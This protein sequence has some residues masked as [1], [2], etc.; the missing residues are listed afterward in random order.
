MLPFLDLVLTWNTGISYGL[1]QQDSAFGRWAL[2]GL[3]IVAS[4]LLWVW[5]ARADIAANALWRSA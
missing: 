1:F 5:L 3:K 4:I 2:F